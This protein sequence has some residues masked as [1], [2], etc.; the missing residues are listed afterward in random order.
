MSNTFV[1]CLQDEMEEYAV[2]L[3][4]TTSIDFVEESSTDEAIADDT[5]VRMSDWELTFAKSTDADTASA[6]G[7]SFFGASDTGAIYYQVAFPVR[8]IFSSLA[9]N[10]LG[11]PP[12]PLACHNRT[13][14]ASFCGGL[15]AN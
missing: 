2:T 10:S 6:A 12:S 9:S 15:L 14:R 7:T 4:V 3:L 8:C 1:V 11:H 5:V 13:A